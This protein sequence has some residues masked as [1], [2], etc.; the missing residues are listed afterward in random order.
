MRVSHAIQ[1]LMLNGASAT[2]IAQQAR[3]E[4]AASL[5]RAGLDK[6]VAGMT[7]LSEVLAETERGEDSGD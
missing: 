5:R 6:V 2:D 4:G 3:Q 1:L 7:S